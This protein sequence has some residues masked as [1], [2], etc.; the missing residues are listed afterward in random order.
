MTIE[1]DIKDLRKRVGQLE[2]RTSALEIENKLKEVK[3]NGNKK[4]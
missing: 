4:I 1:T 2:S 3:K